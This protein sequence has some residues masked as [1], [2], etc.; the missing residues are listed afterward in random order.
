VS[1]LNGMNRY[2]L[3]QPPAV[4]P[5]QAAPMPQASPVNPYKANYGGGSMSGQ[6]QTQPPSVDSGGQP[7]TAPGT[8]GMMGS[9]SRMLGGSGGLDVNQLLQI[10]ASLG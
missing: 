7:A 6:P 1:I 9:I 3:M 10:L 4:H 8:G 2:S 5:L